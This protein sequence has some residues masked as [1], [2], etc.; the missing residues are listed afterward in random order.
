[1]CYSGPPAN[2]LRN[3][4]RQDAAGLRC[5]LMISIQIALTGAKLT[6]V[7]ASTA[8]DAGAI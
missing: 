6:G 7:L 5:F 2:L 4:A 1:M 8:F 3:A